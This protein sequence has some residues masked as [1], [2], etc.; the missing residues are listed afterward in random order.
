MDHRQEV[1]AS[2][3]ELVRQRFAGDYRKA[4]D[5]YDYDKDGKVGRDNIR[6]ILADAG[7]GSRMTRGIWAD[8]VLEELDKDGDGRVSWAEF[9]SAMKP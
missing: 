3:A 6:D 7:V 4:F 1:I 9:E 2:V 5:H 8:K